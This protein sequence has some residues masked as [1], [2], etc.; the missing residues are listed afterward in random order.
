MPATLTTLPPE[1]ILLITSFLPPHAA[2]LLTLV[3]TCRTLAHLISP[4]L[5][6][7]TTKP[8]TSITYSW[9]A[10]VES[11]RCLFQLDNHRELLLRGDPG[12]TTALDWALKN[13][14]VASTIR[15]VIISF[16]AEENEEE[17]WREGLGLEITFPP[18]HLSQMDFLNFTP[19][20]PGEGIRWSAEQKEEYQAAWKRVLDW[21][22]DEGILDSLVPTEERWKKYHW[23]W[24]NPLSEQPDW[25]QVKLGYGTGRQIYDHTLAREVPWHLLTSGAMLTGAIAP[26]IRELTITCGPRESHDPSWIDEV[27]FNVLDDQ[28]NLPNLTTFDNTVGGCTLATMYSLLLRPRMRDITMRLH[29]PLCTLKETE[30][31]AW[32]H[33]P[34]LLHDPRFRCAVRKLHLLFPRLISH[35]WLNELVGMCSSLNELLLYTK[36]F[37]ELIPCRQ[38][39]QEQTEQLLKLFDTLRIHH[40]TTLESLALSFDQSPETATE[41]G[42]PEHM[43]EP[44]HSL[45]LFL[46]YLAHFPSLRKLEIPVWML[47]GRFIFFY[48]DDVHEVPHGHFSELPGR[49]PPLLDSLKLIDRTGFE[50]GSKI[51]AARGRAVETKCILSALVERRKSDHHL[52]P[53]LQK[54]EFSDDMAWKLVK[55][56][57]T[58]ASLLKAA[59]NLGLEVPLNSRV[60]RYL[61]DDPAPQPKIIGFGRSAFTYY[62]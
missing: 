34:I 58:V 3:Q 12:V 57:V 55:T 20:E 48:H 4:L 30:D 28:N 59:K 22:T 40:S 24:E 50:R 54:F 8:T 10:E 47:I 17:L 18:E 16:G 9:D 52:L 26:N 36:G 7:V 49:L 15:E 11:V 21:M 27:L 33:R 19:L 42:P 62:P 41:G 37:S 38:T 39:D 51:H 60:M 53:H 61:R 25:G 5:A 46:P 45:G 43:S 23:N 14:L 56:G 6:P 2:Q 13:R 29:F 31:D 35:G 32:A 1:I 44:Q